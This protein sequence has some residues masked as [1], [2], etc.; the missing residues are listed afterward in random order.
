LSLFVQ[1]LEVFGAGTAV[2]ISPV[3][4]IVYKDE[5]IK[6][7]TAETAGPL[8]NAVWKSLYDIQYGKID[9]PWSVVI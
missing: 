7:P 6:V 8:A 9:H 1:L 4:G 5:E 2:V 3:K